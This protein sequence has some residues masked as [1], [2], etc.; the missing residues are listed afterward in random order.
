MERIRN[1]IELAKASWRVLQK[2]RELLA[3][4]VISFFVSVLVFGVFIIPALVMSDAFD[5]SSEQ[6]TSPMLWILLVAGGLALTIVSVF[7]RGALVSGANERLTG[8]DP[9]VSSAI[10]GA[11]SKIHRLLPWAIVTATVGLILQT[12]R[13]KGGIGRFVAGMLDMAWEVLTFLVLPVIIIEDVGPIA[14]V[15]RSAALFRRTWGE[16]LAARIGFGLLGF[17]AIVPAVLVAGLLV[18]SGVTVLAVVGVVAAVVWIAG[19]VVVLSA[20]G[21][22]FQTALYH[23]AATETLVPG[24]EGTSLATS[25]ASRGA[26]GG[27]AGY[28]GGFAGGR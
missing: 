1:T 23:Y 6:G 17:A 14:G 24:F 5:E 18:A 19:V 4:P 15:K 10:G 22:V 9:T 28:N 25:F 27:G 26:G 2:D 11:M 8:G 13:D 16:N 3:L 21:A 12:I 7:F 20:L